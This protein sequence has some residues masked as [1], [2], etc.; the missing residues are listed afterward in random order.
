MTASPPPSPPPPSPLVTWT[1]AGSDSGGG[2]GIQADLR[3]FHALGLHGCS[4]ITALTAQNSR[5]VEHTEVPEATVLTAQ[6]EALCSDLPPAAV[7][8]GLS[9]NADTIR[10]IAR[11]L[12]RLPDIPVV[13]DP[14]LRPTRGRRFLDDPAVAA[15]VDHLLPRAD[16]ITPNLPEAEALAGRTASGLED[17]P[18]LAGALRARGAKAVLLKGG[19]AEDHAGLPRMHDYVATPHAAGWISTP[20]VDTPHTH[21][22]GCVLSAGITAF[23]AQGYPLPD[24]VVLGRALLYQGLSAAY[25]TGR[26]AGTLGIAGWP[27]QPHALPW[28]TSSPVT[29][30]PDAFAEEAPRSIGLYPIVDRAAWLERLPAMGVTTIQLRAKDLQGEALEAEVERAAR[31]ARAARVRLYI[32]DAWDLALKYGAYGVHLGQDDMATADR[33]ALLKA[34]VRLGL[35]THGPAEMARAAAWRPSYI[36]L[37]TVYTS[38]SKTFEH[39]PLGPERFRRLRPLCPV[40]CVAIGGITVENAPPLLA[41]GADGVAVISEVT[42][43]PRLPERLRAWRALLNEHS[44]R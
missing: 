28:W 3:V 18:D 16:L 29:E 1:I 22:T 32:N 27:E 2:A 9:G 34:G 5:G 15:W 25:P 35:S 24:A 37:G 21:G 19:H 30:P 31:L 12:D 44:T 7:K 14:V 11:V 20:R 38:P 40:P 43:A 4:A 39:I 26:G 10:A 6:L 17:L 8:I 36:A 42:K 23:L 13:I 41:A 33:D